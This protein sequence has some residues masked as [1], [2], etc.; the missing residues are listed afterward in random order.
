MD[1]TV[2]RIINNSNGEIVGSYS[3][4]YNDEYDFK[5]VCEARTANVHGMFKNKEKYSI[6]KYLIIE[7]LIKE[8]CDK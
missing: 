1:K 3:R 4:S 6:N 8:N 2:Y 5:S 7:K